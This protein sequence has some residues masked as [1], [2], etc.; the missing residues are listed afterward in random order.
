MI[1]NYHHWKKSPFY[2]QYGMNMAEMG[3]RIGI[4][5]EA[6]RRRFKK[7][8]KVDAPIKKP[9]PLNDRVYKGK[10]YGEWAKELKCSKEVIEWRIKHNNNP[11]LIPKPKPKSKP[12]QLDLFGWYEK[13][14]IILERFRLGQ[15]K[16]REYNEEKM[17]KKERKDPRVI[18][19]GPYKGQWKAKKQIR[20]VV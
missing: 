3:R 11:I 10:T 13:E 8:L 12:K 4:S 6:V 18:L 15:I 9:V 17:L 16:M 5:K 1:K 2:K 19:S 14:Q 20:K 7:G